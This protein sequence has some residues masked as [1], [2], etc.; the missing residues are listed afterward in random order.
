MA[1]GILIFALLK[2]YKNGRDQ[3]FSG[4]FIPG[5]KEHGASV[6]KI[7]LFL[8]FFANQAEQMKIRIGQTGRPHAVSHE[9]HKIL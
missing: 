6:P 3:E 1:H 9:E 4:P 8:N 7:G 5:L 2:T